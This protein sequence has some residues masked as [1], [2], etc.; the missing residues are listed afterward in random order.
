MPLPVMRADMVVGSPEWAK[1]TIEYAKTLWQ[2]VDNSVARWR[3]V[4]D[5][6][7]QGRAWEPLGK[8]TLDALLIAELGVTTSTSLE[9]VIAQARD[10]GPL[11]PARRPTKEEQAGKVDVIKLKTDGGTGAAY[12]SR[13]LLR[14]A[15]DTFAAMERGEFRSVRAAAKAAGIIRERTPLEQMERLWTNLTHEDRLTFLRW[16]RTP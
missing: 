6:L 1:A 7:Q 8:P 2:S 9:T 13:R 4:L 5:E 10:A 3:A 16:A 12:L 11:A 15:P 14:D